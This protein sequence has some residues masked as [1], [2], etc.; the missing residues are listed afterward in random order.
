MGAFEVAVVLSL[1]A[2]VL[3]LFV[4]EVLPVPVT[5]ML[6][7]AILMLVPAQSWDG[8]IL[9]PEEGLS[10]FSSQATVAILAMFVLSAGVERSGAVAFISNRLS[11]V[12]G[13]SPRRQAV[14]LGAV[15]G[16][17]SGF[18]NNTPV[19]AVLM[20]VA[21][22]LAREAGHSPGRLLM[23]L[24]FFAM[25]GGTLT[26]VGTSTSLLG[27]D[28]LPG[29][30]IK[31]FGFFEFTLVGIVGLAVA[32]VYFATFGMSLMPRRGD[33]DAVA[34]FDLQ[35]F[36][37]ELEV[38]GDSPSVGLDLHDAGLTRK[39]G[40]QVVRIF[41]GDRVISSPRHMFRLEPGDLLMVQGSR[42]RLEALPEKTGLR[43]LAELLHS[44]DDI[45]PGVRQ[46]AVGTAE[47]IVPP[48]S[49][50]VGRS[51]RQLRFRDRF[52]ALVIA[53]R[54]HERV[55]FGTLADT[56]LRPGDVLLVQG[57]P[58]ALARLEENALF[59]LSRERH[60]EV[61]RHDKIA[62]AL[63]ILLSVVVL[64]ALGWTPLVTA[65]L[66]GAVAMVLTGCLRIN[67]FLGSIHWD[68]ILLLAGIIPLGLAVQKSGA[69]DLLA[70]GLAWVG[71]Y[72]PPLAFLI[73]VFL[74]TSL[75]TEMVSNNASVVLLVPVVVAAAISLGLDGR[76]F[77]LAVMLSA[78]TSMLTPV[79]YQTNTMVYAPGGYRFTDYLRV[80][81]PLN[82]ILVVVLPLMIAWLFPL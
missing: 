27:N 67:E 20:P 34:R 19:V 56:V 5:A 22:R 64:A 68:I 35:G 41:R 73:L 49:T 39:D 30:G 60:Q 69:S 70:S 53:I 47:L 10:G 32:M 13:R 23:P 65:A 78:S 81:G 54:H 12:A 2:L 61:F 63:G 79:G 33:G 40:V 14:T 62:I 72:L 3:W 26:L 74:A 58:D 80:G 6:A 25:L 52:D 43:S 18:V 4:R 8:A 28:L 11:R 44:L 42:D 75:V 57:H 50:V 31:P 17:L 66:A 24:S 45:N 51:L 16:P 48:G 82:L 9:S 29:L 71:G 15:A 55:A 1:V 59:Y 36:M 21:S 46:E 77:A 37:A 76:P 7:A 38:A